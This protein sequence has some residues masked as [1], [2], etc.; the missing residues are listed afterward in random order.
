MRRALDLAARGQG[1]VE[2]N[3]MVG[4]VLVRDGR[5]IGEGFH[6]HFG[7]PHA[8]VNA[9][10]S[11]RGSPR[12]ATAFVTLEPCC[13]HG[14]TPPCTD[15]LIASGVRRVVAAMRDPNP[16]VSG[17]G[18]RLL[19]RAGIAVQAGILQA[20]AE[21]LAAP[22]VS[23][24][25]RKRP[26]V[27]LKW[28][29]SLD[30]RIATRTGDSK[31]I[32]GPESRAHAHATRGRVDAI[33]VGIGTVL[34]DDPSLT[35]R[36]GPLLRTAARIVLD[37]RLRT[38]LRS[39]IVRSA[40]ATPTLLYCDR[41]AAESRRAGALRKAGCEV[42]A[43]SRTARG[44]ALRRILTDLGARDM[45]NVLVEGGGAVLGAFLDADL[46]DEAHIYVA[47]RL[48]GGRNAT[49]AISGRGFPTLAEA[50]RFSE[51][52][53]IRLLGDDLLVSG[54]ITRLQ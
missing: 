3:P 23:L 7:G 16:R 35:C 10:R 52:P 36:D 31:W 37:S 46:G 45:A 22:F 21:N 17:G 34:S 8:E 40:R 6:Q 4:C 53:T 32:S 38:P 49:P 51:P 54:R 43:V 42:V 24:M 14:K 27:I 13:Y 5:I 48:I 1:R 12:G 25:L 44:L 28:A 33:L 20:E 9:L 26:W 15:A 18:L 11:C 47:P 41:A 29:Q 2:P 19:R 50:A 30:G 39:Q